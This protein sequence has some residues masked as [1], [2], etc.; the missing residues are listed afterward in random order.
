MQPHL[1]VSG[2]RRFLLLAALVVLLAA[3]GWAWFAFRARPP[4][5]PTVD[6]SGADP[7]AAEA[8]TTA[9]AEVRSR[10]RSG[11]S[12]GR[13]GMLLRAHGF[14]TEANVCFAKAERLDPTEARWP[15]LQ[16]LTLVLTD[17]ERG[18]SS[19]ERAVDRLGDR[20]LAPR[21][22][23]ADV[24]AE[25]GRTDEAERH[26]R[27]VL[28]R[29]PGNC[30]ARIGLARLLLERQEWQAV[31]EMVEPCAGNPQARVKTLQLRA[32]A[33]N[34]LGERQKAEDALQEARTLPP[35]ADWSDPFVEEVERLQRGVN[36]R[37]AEAQALARTGRGPQAVAL[38]EETLRRR[39]DSALAW[40]TLGRI[41]LE[42]GD[43]VAAERALEEAV[44][45]DREMVE[46]WFNLGVVRAQ[47]GKAAAAA[48]CFQRTVA[49][50]KD[51]ALA[52]F[53]LGVCRKQLG[54]SAA[55]IESFRAALRC[56]PDYE[57]ARKALQEMGQDSGR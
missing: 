23:L 38:L 1:V 22:R 39:P 45:R 26:L 56:R 19:L 32:A 49:L 14:G 47:Q 53:N 30:R 15:Y 31:L 5:P 35:D 12:W 50:K 43:P 33:W 28:G 24:L 17:P 9:L 40:E 7:E 27:Q 4:E 21:L 44:K 10:P 13:L 34:G 51:H 29:E 3:G 36:V 18:I 2:R 11:T 46:G 16:G 20:S 55:A 48:E 41:W 6:L 54:E 42:M 37:L 57:P 25:Q 8:I 52:H